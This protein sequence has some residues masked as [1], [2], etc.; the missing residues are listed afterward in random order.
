MTTA[1]TRPWIAERAAEINAITAIEPMIRADERAKTEREIVARIRS[2][3]DIHEGWDRD[4]MDN[5]VEPSLSILSA[6]LVSKLSAMAELRSLLRE[7]E[8]SKP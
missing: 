4:T 5:G 8:G 7:L 2:R 3:L 1:S 6:R